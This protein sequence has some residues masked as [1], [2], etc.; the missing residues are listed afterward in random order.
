MPPFWLVG[1]IFVDDWVVSS[2]EYWTVEPIFSTDLRRMLRYS[3]M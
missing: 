3:D 2:A 1:L